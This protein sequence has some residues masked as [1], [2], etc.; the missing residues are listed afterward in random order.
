MNNEPKW[1]VIARERRALAD[2]LAGLTAE[3]LEQHS[4][5]AQWRVR[6]VAAH[7]ELTPRSP[8][9]GRILVRAV[10]ARFDF[11]A[12]N[13]DLAIEHADRSPSQL[14][15]ELRDLSTNRRKPAITTLDNLLFDVLVHVQDVAVPLGLTHAMPLEAAPAKERVGSGGWVGPSG[16]SGSCAGF[17]SRPPTPRGAPGPVSRCEA[18]FRR[19]CCCSPGDSSPRGPR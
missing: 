7:V 11:D 1:A 17:D 6:D 12:I 2:L 18:R 5:C 8:G 3:Q 9:T 13:R 19:L 15:A 10:R 14:V 16:P 4:L